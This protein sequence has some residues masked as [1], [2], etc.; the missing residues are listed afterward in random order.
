M[1]SREIRVHRVGTHLAVRTKGHN[2]V[3]LVLNYLDDVCPEEFA[4]LRVGACIG[5]G[6]PAAAHLRGGP[7]IE[8][9]L[10][11]NYRDGLCICDPGIAKTRKQRLAVV[12][13]TK[14]FRIDISMHQRRKLRIVGAVESI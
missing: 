11:I 14:S 9:L 12:T 3:S 1:N 2:S 13:D 4:G 5:C 7:L 10:C 8:F 6:K